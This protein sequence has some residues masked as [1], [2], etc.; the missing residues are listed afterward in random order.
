M[1]RPP[2]IQKYNCI[3]NPIRKPNGVRMSNGMLTS[4]GKVPMSGRLDPLIWRYAKYMIGNVVNIVVPKP[5]MT[6]KHFDS[7]SDI[8]W[9]HKKWL[10]LYGLSGMWKRQFSRTCCDA[11]AIKFTV[12]QVLLKVSHDVREMRSTP[13]QIEE[14]HTYSCDRKCDA[15]N[16]LHLFRVIVGGCHDELTLF[17]LDWK[18]GVFAFVW[19]NVQYVLPATAS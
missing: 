9:A 2:H 13:N 4:N 14:R 10:I 6:S 17:G 3:R 5:K 12:I 8:R 18:M 11:Y 1:F 15:Q 19:A 16:R 7:C